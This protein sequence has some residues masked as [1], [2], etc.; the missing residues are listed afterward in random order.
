MKM[1]ACVFSGQGSQKA[2][3]G[4]ELC[5]QNSAARAIYAAAADHLGMDL[6]SLDDE[7]LSQTRFAQLSIVTLGRFQGGGQRAAAHGFRR[8]FA[9]R[10]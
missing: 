3:M 6:L 7:A 4:Q 8:L 1:I 2:G 9:R 5:S 10:V